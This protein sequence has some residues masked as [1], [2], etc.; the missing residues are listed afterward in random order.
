MCRC[1]M[2][3]CKDKRNKIANCEKICRKFVKIVENLLVLLPFERKCVKLI[4][5]IVQYMIMHWTLRGG[6]E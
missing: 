1:R 3:I 5:E 4:E 2:W 6:K